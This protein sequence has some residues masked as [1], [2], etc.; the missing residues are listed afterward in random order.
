MHTTCIISRVESVHITSAGKEVIL[1]TFL[2]SI[3]AMK[4]KNAILT[5]D[6]LFIAF[7]PMPKT[8]SIKSHWRING[9]LER[10]STP[11]SDDGHLF[12][13]VH[14]NLLHHLIFSCLLFGCKWRNDINNG[15]RKSFVSYHIFSYHV[16]WIFFD[17]SV[18]SQYWEQNNTYQ[19]HI[20]RSI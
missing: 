8:R 18:D 1:F 20:K 12:F 16:N 2:Q 15:F 6:I 10:K 9:G 3:F 4:S 7:P 5:P 19:C 14:E 11:L 13:Q 17:D